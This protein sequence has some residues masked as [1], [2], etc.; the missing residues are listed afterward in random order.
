MADS[1]VRNTL[2]EIRQDKLILNAKYT[3]RRSDLDGHYSLDQEGPKPFF[4][5]RKSSVVLTSA[6]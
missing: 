6:L 5:A 4:A 3:D 1:Y 2:E